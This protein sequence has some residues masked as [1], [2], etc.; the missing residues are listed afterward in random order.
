MPP[1]GATARTG[2]D[3]EYAIF[4]IVLHFIVRFNARYFA[5]MME[6]LQ[7]ARIAAVVQTGTVEI[8]FRFCRSD[9]L[10][11]RLSGSKKASEAKRISQS[12]CAHC[13]AG[14]QDAS[15][16]SVHESNL[17]VQEI[18]KAL[19]YDGSCRAEAPFRSVARGKQT[20]DRQADG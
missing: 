16:L 10:C 5:V 2:P 7:D 1:H 12:P 11:R 8:S 14:F 3:L 13:R 9:G 18:E 6:H 4:P 19:T 15:S 20:C 17:T